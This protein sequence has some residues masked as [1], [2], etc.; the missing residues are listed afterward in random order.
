MKLY[1][2][3]RLALTN[4]FSDGDADSEHTLKA[5]TSI[6]IEERMAACVSELMQ[7]WKPGRATDQLHK[8]DRTTVLDRI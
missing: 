8:D 4:P 3:I 1:E 2:E 6:E 7:L 5:H